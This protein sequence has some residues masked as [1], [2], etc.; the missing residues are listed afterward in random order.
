[1]GKFD[2][3]AYSLIDASYKMC[4]VQ[5]W[6]QAIKHRVIHNQITMQLQASIT[7]NI[8]CNI[9]CIASC[10][11]HSPSL[12]ACPALLGPGELPRAAAHM[13]ISQTQHIQTPPCMRSRSH[14]SQD[15]S[16]V[17]TPRFH[18]CIL[19][20]SFFSLPLDA[21]TSKQ[22]DLHV[23]TSSGSSKSG[24][25]KNFNILSA[26]TW[27]TPQPCFYLE[28]D[29]QMCCVRTYVRAKIN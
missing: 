14:R 21:K 13:H 6:L 22:I 23:F 3:N 20:T 4:L 8:T 10:N 24:I 12:P 11:M 27:S 19:K 25:K 17:H 9:T 16:F 7:C 5:P 18:A 15:R 1:M 28:C 2:K 29:F 26:S